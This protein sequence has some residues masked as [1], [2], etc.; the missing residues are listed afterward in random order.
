M[1]LKKGLDKWLVEEKDEQVKKQNEVV[2]PDMQ[3]QLAT[4][5]RS[6]GINCPKCAHKFPVT[7][8]QL[9]ASNFIICPSC[10]LRL[11]LN[12][13]KSKEALEAMEKLFTKL[14]K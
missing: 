12:R 13:E 4:F 2:H 3:P 5:D 8:E 10:A 14:N 7:I 11:E 1:P 6:P 9:L